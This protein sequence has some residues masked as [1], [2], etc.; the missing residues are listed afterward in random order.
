MHDYHDDAKASKKLQKSV[1]NYLH[2][3]KA[4][5]WV[6]NLSRRVFYYNVNTNSLPFSLDLQESEIPMNTKASCRNRQCSSG[7]LV[8][9]QHLSISSSTR[10]SERERKSV[11]RKA[12]S[13][14]QQCSKQAASRDAVVPL[15]SCRHGSVSTGALWLWNLAPGVSYPFIPISCLHCRDKLKTSV[16][17]HCSL[18]LLISFGNVQNRKQWKKQSLCDIRT[19]CCESSPDS[20]PQTLSGHLY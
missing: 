10:L 14:G 18:S 8:L 19:T 15:R 9:S 5:I 1:T 2:I 11:V 4:S 12:D 20:L 13:W 16:R 6:Y 3:Y 7:P 17:K